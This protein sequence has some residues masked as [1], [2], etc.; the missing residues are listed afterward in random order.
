MRI[1]GGCLSNFWVHVCGKGC[2]QSMQFVGWECME[3]SGACLTVFA[4]L[5]VGSRLTVGTYTLHAYPLAWAQGPPGPQAHTIKTIN[6]ANNKTIK[7]YNNQ[8]IKRQFNKKH[9]F[10]M[11]DRPWTMGPRGCGPIEKFEQMLEE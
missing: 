3:R 11:V 10:E 9:V 6:R 2:V 7:S 1:L 8:T 4:C 5:T